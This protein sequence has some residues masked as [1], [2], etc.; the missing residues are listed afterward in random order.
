M[1]KS[2]FTI[3]G[4]ERCGGKR[5]LRDCRRGLEDLFRLW[6]S[7]DS[8]VLRID[9]AEGMKNIIYKILDIRDFYTEFWIHLPSKDRIVLSKCLKTIHQ[10]LCDHKVG[11][12]LVKVVIQGETITA[13]SP[14][15]I[16]EAMSRYISAPDYRVWGGVCCCSV[17]VGE[18]CKRNE[19]SRPQVEVQ[20]RRHGSQQKDDR[21]ATRVAR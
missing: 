8:V 5:S 10:L 17:S 11:Q 7:K 21:D 15:D 20:C 6:A 2:A 12:N 9:N 18:S 19:E 13:S 14:A 16:F 3:R 4:D 1:V